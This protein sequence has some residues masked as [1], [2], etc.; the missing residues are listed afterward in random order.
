MNV[1]VCHAVTER[2]VREA[3]AA[4]VRTFEELTMRTGCGGTCSPRSERL[5]ASGGIAA[6]WIRYALIRVG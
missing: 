6:G 5:D 4:G 3:A 1:C 2:A